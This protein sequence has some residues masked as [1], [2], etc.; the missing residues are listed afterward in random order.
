MLTVTLSCA[1]LGYTEKLSAVL[2]SSSLQPD[3]KLCVR[4]PLTPQVLLAVTLTLPAP[5]P[6][7]TSM[8]LLPCPADMVPFG[9]SQLYPGSGETDAMLKFT[10]P[11]LHHD[12]GF[13]VIVPGMPGLP[14]R[15]A[16]LAGPLPGVQALLLAVTDKVPVVNVDPTV[17]KMVG[18]FC[19]LVIVVP[20]GFVQV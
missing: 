16:V 6:Q 10:N 14:T 8:L 13:A 17:N 18:V 2:S 4:M 11:P 7:V 1:G 12:K 9:A 15:V 3:V 20:A 19:P 5:V